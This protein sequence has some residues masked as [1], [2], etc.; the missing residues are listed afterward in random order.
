MEESKSKISLIIIEL[1]EAIIKIYL[2][3]AGK[4]AL[5]FNKF[6]NMA[7]TLATALISLFAIFIFALTLWWLSMGLLFIYIQYLGLTL[8]ST[9]LILVIVNIS[10]LLCVLI[11]FLN[12]RKKLLNQF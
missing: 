11:K 5:L 1:V 9:I 8:I 4:S 10:L 3:Y 12:L 7:N 6:A 2:E